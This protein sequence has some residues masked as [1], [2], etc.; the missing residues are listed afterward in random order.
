MAEEGREAE[1]AAGGPEAEMEVEVEAEAEAAQ[2]QVAQGQ[3]EE[4][5]AEADAVAVDAVV[6]DAELSDPLSPVIPELIESPPPVIEPVTDRD[7]SGDAITT[8][9]TIQHANDP[10]YTFAQCSLATARNLLR[11]ESLPRS[12]LVQHQAR[13]VDIHGQTE[14]E[15]RFPDWRTILTPLL[16]DDSEVVVSFDP[17]AIGTSELLNDVRLMACVYPSTTHVVAVLRHES[18]IGG[19]IGF[20]KYD[21]DSEARRRGTYELT[22][23]RRLWTRAN[24]TAITTAG[25]TLHRAVE[26]FRMRPREQI[27]LTGPRAPTG[28][29]M[30][31]K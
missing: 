5:G 20:R 11:N 4:M 23:A 28:R 3:A 7:L 9:Q 12:F 17:T 2:A 16:R 13:G 26:A 18:L 27:N 25:S 21:N 8:R 31:R 19:R 24:M 29:R 1:A 15:I 6:A 22:S 14:G 30:A 10:A